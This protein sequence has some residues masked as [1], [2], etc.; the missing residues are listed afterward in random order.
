MFF[1]TEGLFYQLLKGV[2]DPNMSR[3][4]GV[5]IKSISKLFRV[6]QLFVS[7]WRKRFN[8]NSHFS[9]YPSHPHLISFLKGHVHIENKY[10]RKILLSFIM[11]TYLSPKLRHAENVSFSLLKFTLISILSPHSIYMAET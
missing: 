5:K 10:I 9:Y 1:R 7:F 6:N 8:H 3:S 2:H 4:T 11:G